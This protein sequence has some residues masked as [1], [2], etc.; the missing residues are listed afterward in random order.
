VAPYSISPETPIVAI[1]FEMK[2]QGRHMGVIRRDGEVVG[3]IT[4]EDI[5]ERFVGAI[6]D[7]FN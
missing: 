3:M 7:E 4:L 2:E 1:L 5:L 6:A